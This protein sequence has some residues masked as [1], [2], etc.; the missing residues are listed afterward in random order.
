M[1]CRTWGI[2]YIL[3]MQH[4]CPFIRLGSFILLPLPPRVPLPYLL[5][6]EITFLCNENHYGILSISSW[7]AEEG[8]LAAVELSTALQCVCLVCPIPI[9]LLILI[10]KV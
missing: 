3:D 9:H 2:G 5:F 7:P 10:P 1:G 4:S 8:S 6:I